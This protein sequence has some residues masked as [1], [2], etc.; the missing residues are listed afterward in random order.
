MK[1]LKKFLLYIGFFIVLFIVGFKIAE[2]LNNK[3][4]TIKH[5]QLILGTIVE[6][7]VR[8]SDEEKAEK[9]ISKAFN[10]IRRIDD[11]FSTYNSESPVWKINHSED[12]AFITDSE[13]FKLIQN[14]DSLSK[15]TNNAFDV[16]LDELIQ[17]WG[18]DKGKPDIPSEEIRLTAL[19]HSGW[20]NIELLR[21][22]II[23][24]NNVQLNFGAVAKGYAVDK[25]VEA[26][27]E[28]HITDALVNA[29]GE[30]RA[31]GNEWIVGIQHPRIPGQL[32]ERLILDEYSVATSGDYEQYFEKNGIRYHH[33][34]NPQTGYPASDCR[35]VTV[36][37]KDDMTADALATGVFVLGPEKGLKLIEKLK[38]IESLIIDKKG[39][40]IKSSGF[41]KFILR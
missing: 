27:E 1:Y 2:V 22:K 30:I 35:S 8:N 19:K 25:A 28:N 39:N 3:T 18:F 34:L 4:K 29:G 26:L 38:N 12:S 36:I 31:L 33:I 23:R 7:Q 13:I 37:A 5:T 16:S 10:E 9:A 15:L 11:V 6:I 40:I 14:C 17:V 41:N 24:R 32:L 21:N 20:S